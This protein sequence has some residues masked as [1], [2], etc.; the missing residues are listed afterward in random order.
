[1]G[2][3]KG[4]P[5][6]RDQLPIPGADPG[7][8]IGGGADLPGGRQHTTILPTFPKKKKKM[9]EI[10]KSL[11]RRGGRTPGTPPLDPS[12]NSTSKL[13]HQ[14]KLIL[15]VFVNTSS[16]IPFK[17]RYMT[18]KRCISYTMHKPFGHVLSKFMTYCDSFTLIEAKNR[19]GKPFPCDMRELRHTCSRGTDMKK[20]YT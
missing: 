12:L 17:L 8:P 11:S 20:G 19:A 18:E 2:H 3:Q 16:R 15:I 14:Y 9:H 10:E 4:Q 5:P 1:M 6:L 13:D 7:F